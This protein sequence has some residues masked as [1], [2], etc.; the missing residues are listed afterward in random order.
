MLDPRTIY[1]QHT[2][3]CVT[4][5]VDINGS[6]KLIDAGEDGLTGQFFRDLLNGGIQAVESCNGSVINFTG[7]GFIAILPTET[8]AAHACWNLAR[9]L[10]KSREY[11]EACRTDCTESWPQ[12]DIGVGLKIAIES[13][14]LEVSTISSAFLGVQPFLIGPPTVYASRISAFGKG[15]RCVIGPRAAAKWPYAGLEG[16]FEGEV[17]HKGLK[18]QYYFYDLSDFWGD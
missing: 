3:S 10:R 5:I 8:D 14:Q 18:Y 7:D 17:K 13:G 15:D 12:L 9:D 16:P 4:L 11:L 2:V 6:E 1:E